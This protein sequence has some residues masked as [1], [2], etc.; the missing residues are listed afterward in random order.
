M[1][2]SDKKAYSDQKDLDSETNS[3]LEE[4]M[5]SGSST[6]EPSTNNVDAQDQNKGG[7]GLTALARAQADVGVTEDLGHNDGKRIREYFAPFG[8]KPP[9][10]W[11]AAAL[12]SWIKGGPVQGSVGA[13]AIMGQFIQANK[14]VPKANLTSKDLVPGNIVVWHRGP[15]NSPKGHI[16]IIESSNGGNLTTI[17]ANSGPRSDSVARMTRPVN[18]SNLLGVGILS[19]NSSEKKSSRKEILE[20]ISKN[21]EKFNEIFS[22]LDKPLPNNKRAVRVAFMEKL[23]AELNLN[24]NLTPHE[25]QV[26]DL[27]MQVVKNKSPDTTLRAAGGWVRDKL[28]GKESH[29]ID[30]AVDNMSGAQ[31]ANLVLEWMK[32]N[33]IKGA[34]NVTKVEANPDANKNLETAMLPILGTSIDFVQLRKDTYDENSRNP[35]IQVGVSA[36]EDAQRRDLTINAIFYNLNIDKIEDYVGGIEDLRKGIAR[37]P[38]DPL[39]TYLEDPLRIL[40]AVRFAAKYDLQ[41]DPNLVEAA[42]N[43]KVQDAFR[44]KITKERIWTELV[45]QQEGEGWK[46]G[47]MIG[48]NFHRAAE[49]MGLLGLRDL[50]LTPT[51]EQMDR[52]I[53]KQKKLEPRHEGEEAKP[54]KWEKGFTTWE[55]NQNNPH[56]DLD[57]WNHTLATL[58]YLHNL[59]LSNVS[60]GRKIKETDEIVRNLAMLFHDIGKCDICSRQEDPRGYSTYHEHELSS[61]AIAEEILT[62]LKAPNDIKDRVVNL[63]KN[64]MRL[65]TLP[66]GV[67]GAGLRRIVR[68]VG[69]DWPNLV[70]MSKSD[71]MGKSNVKELDAK[72]ENFAKIID[73]FLARTGG[74]SETPPP[75][76]GHEIMQALNLNQ[77]IDGKK[78]GIIT[79][80][81]KEKLLE[82]PEMTKEE[83]LTYIKTIPL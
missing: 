63:V 21:T 15:T 75:I 24:F 10:D 2:I 32:E 53:A 45:G 68:D 78:I 31:F 30:I 77:K 22:I 6:S 71:S 12:S 64:H 4:L 28:M 60:E 1:A 14:W 42:K 69:Q 70:D 51:Q 34:K 55:L 3:L 40:R 8:M 61:A 65:H 76:N 79:K 41:L 62:D 20:K 66:S 43:P 16:G 46:R 38:I 29:D 56:H 19:D 73:Q 47:L 67:S 27:L 57:V 36:E 72:Y 33:N 23:A 9:Q 5:G 50:I 18:D 37:T 25:R 7:F 58:K 44:N 35:E 80:S 74:K 13:K 11:C 52:A 81:L 82:D 39:R 48:P 83:A 49:L 54:R 17:E 26:F 59:H